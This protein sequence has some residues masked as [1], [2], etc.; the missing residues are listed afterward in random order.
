MISFGRFVKVKKLIVAQAVEKIM[1][2][3]TLYFSSV[4]LA[5]RYCNQEGVWEP[6]D[7]INCTSE[8]FVNMSLEVRV[9]ISIVSKICNYENC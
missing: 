8:A 9:F 1:I 2:H 3:V 7:S 5:T 6:P 4:G